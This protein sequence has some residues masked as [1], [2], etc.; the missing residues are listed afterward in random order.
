MTLYQVRYYNTLVKETLL[1]EQLAITIKL[2][3]S[4]ESFM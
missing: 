1:Y 2:A 4:A 3:K